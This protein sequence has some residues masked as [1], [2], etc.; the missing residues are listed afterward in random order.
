MSNGEVMLSP[1]TSTEAPNC[2][3]ISMMFVLPFL[4]AIMIGVSSLILVCL[5]L[6][7]SLQW[8]RSFFYMLSSEL[9]HFFYQLI[10]TRHPR[11]EEAY[12]QAQ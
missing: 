3:G 1:L 5:G 6:R 10:L 8:I 11:I 2:T 12:L 7:S 9:F 4:H